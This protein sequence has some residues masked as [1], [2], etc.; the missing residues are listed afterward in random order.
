M[1]AVLTSRSTKDAE[2]VNALLA[3]A[4]AVVAGELG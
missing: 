1:L 3:E 4:A 2:Q